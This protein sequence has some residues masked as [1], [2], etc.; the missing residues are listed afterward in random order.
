MSFDCTDGAESGMNRWTKIIKKG[1]GVSGYKTAELIKSIN[2]EDL[3][4]QSSRF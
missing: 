4:S 2:L 1:V 3:R